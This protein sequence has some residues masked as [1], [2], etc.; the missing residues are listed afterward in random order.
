MAVPEGEL[1]AGGSA[2][3]S[4]TAVNRPHRHVSH[5]TIAD[6]GASTSKPEW[7]KTFIQWEHLK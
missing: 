7:R 2:G 4:F 3:K 6:V 5:R 1:V